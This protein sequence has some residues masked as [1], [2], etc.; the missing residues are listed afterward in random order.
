MC[1]SQIY[2]VW[3]AALL[4]GNFLVLGGMGAAAVVYVYRDGER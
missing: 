3:L 4:V 1:F 2:M